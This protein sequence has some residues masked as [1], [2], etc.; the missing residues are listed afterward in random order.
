[1]RTTLLPSS[2]T[3]TPNFS[4]RFTRP[5]TT[6]PPRNSDSTRSPVLARL[7]A[8]A[9]LQDSRNSNSIVNTIK[10]SI[11]G[12]SRQAHQCQRISTSSSSSSSSSSSA[13][14]SDAAAAAVALADIVAD[15]ITAGHTLATKA[16]LAAHATKLQRQQQDGSWHW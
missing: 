12:I 6:S 3:N 9:D 4:T 10:D 5:A 11:G 1:M 16:F 7:L 8:P 15:R 13:A 2:S 14:A